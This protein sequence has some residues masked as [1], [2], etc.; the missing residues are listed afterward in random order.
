MVIVALP[1][2]FLGVSSEAGLGWM[3]QRGVMCTASV[4]RLWQ[5][6]FVFMRHGCGHHTCWIGLASAVQ[7]DIDSV[8]ASSIGSDAECTHF[9]VLRAPSYLQACVTRMN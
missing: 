9:I 4:V 7:R 1:Q 8:F 3:D 6:G 5:A 2:S